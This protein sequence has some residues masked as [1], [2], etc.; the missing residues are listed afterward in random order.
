MKKLTF[1]LF[2]A[3][4]LM[5]GLCDETKA[6]RIVRVD[7]STATG[8]KTGLTNW[9]YLMP[10][11]SIGSGS[12]IDANG[13][14]VTG[15]SV[16]VNG[17]GAADDPKTQN[18]PGFGNDPYCVP[19]AYDRIFARPGLGLTLIMQT[20]FHINRSATRASAS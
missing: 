18:W 19:A 15:L 3:A 16:S 14:V 17:T 13:S 20:P 1:V 8:P 4:V 9:N 10:N 11:S 2:A 7:L 6:E 5:F 12:V